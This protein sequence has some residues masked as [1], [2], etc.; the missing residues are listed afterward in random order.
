MKKSNLVLLIATATVVL[1]GTFGLIML[2]GCGGGGDGGGSASSVQGD[3][4]SFAGGQA[5]WIPSG[6]PE[7]KGMLAQ[8]KRIV[9]PG[10]YAAVG[11]VT[12]SIP[13]TNIQDVTGAGGEFELHG[14]PAGTWDVVFTFEGQSVTF[15]LNVPANAKV[16]LEHVVVVNGTVN[17]A[18]I[19][20]EIEDEDEDDDGI[21]D[22]D[23]LDDDNDGIDDDDDLDD[24]NP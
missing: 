6:L 2:T 8:V 22:D 14:V 24:D 23:D 11:G 19:K 20:V 9:L 1:L 13:G 4:V 17:V 18:N 7:Q 15:P 16:E 10:A 5:R 21:D 3:V 12:V